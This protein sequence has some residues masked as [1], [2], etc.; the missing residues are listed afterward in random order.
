MWHCDTFGTKAELV[1]CFYF[2]VGLMDW[3][4]V[5]CKVCVTT[6]ITFMA[7]S[8]KLSSRFFSGLDLLSLKCSEVLIYTLIFKR[9][10]VIKA[11]LLWWLSGKGSSCNAGDSGSIPGSGRSPGE[12]NGN[13]LQYSCLGIPWTEKPGG[14]QST[15]SQGRT[16][17][18]DF[19]FHFLWHVLGRP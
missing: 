10:K 15:G 9:K 11:G 3:S 18:S 6:Y 2:H 16:W 1:F 17:L 12:G 13:P 8:I 7:W 5:S 14:L 4:S 19:T